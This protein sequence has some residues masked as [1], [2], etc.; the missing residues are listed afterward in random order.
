MYLNKIA[1]NKIN[2]LEENINN[3]KN[4]KE[5]KLNLNNIPLPYRNLAQYYEKELDGGL[6]KAWK[7]VVAELIEANKDPKKF[8]PLCED[9]AGNTIILD[10][11]RKIYFLDHE[12]NK[13]KEIKT[14]KDLAIYSGIFPQINISSN[15]KTKKGLF[16]KDFDEKTIKKIEE[17]IS[18]KY[19]LNLKIDKPSCFK[20]DC[21][22]NVYLENL[23]DNFTKLFKPSNYRKLKELEKEKITKI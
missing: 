2:R 9:G 7:Y 3:L 16:K 18:K 5:I 4:V 15:L 10:S 17:Y 13:L 22:S 20:D 21:T 8:V 11:T 6:F 23:L 19:K 14:G 1:L 12:G